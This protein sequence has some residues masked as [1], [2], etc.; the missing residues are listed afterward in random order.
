M[1]FISRYLRFFAKHLK[2][3]CQKHLPVTFWVYIGDN[4]TLVDIETVVH[5]VFPTDEVTFHDFLQVL[6]T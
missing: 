2:Q 4:T 5:D 6:D 3:K 1:L